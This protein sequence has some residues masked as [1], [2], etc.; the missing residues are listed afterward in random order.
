MVVTGQEGYLASALIF[1]CPHTKLHFYCE[2]S[3]STAQKPESR[4]QFCAM[5]FKQKIK[6]YLIRTSQGGHYECI[7][8]PHTV[9][10][11]AN[12]LAALLDV[13]NVAALPGRIAR[14]LR[15]VNARRAA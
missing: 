3:F 9:N 4:V 12:N 10:L 8:T 11:A 7:H 15:D 14:C 13:R 1:T 6:C 5:F 2:S